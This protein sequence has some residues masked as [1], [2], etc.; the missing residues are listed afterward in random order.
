MCSGWQDMYVEDTMPVCWYTQITWCCLMSVNAQCPVWW[1]YYNTP[2]SSIIVI[3]KQWQ[4]YTNECL[5][6]QIFL[7]KSYLKPVGI[8]WKGPMS[9]CDEK[10]FHV[11]FF[12]VEWW[13][14]I[15]SDFVC[16]YIVCLWPGEDCMSQLYSLSVQ[17]TNIRFSEMFTFIGRTVTSTSHRWGGASGL[18]LIYCLHCK[19]LHCYMKQKFVSFPSIYD[20]FYSVGSVFSQYK[21][22]IFVKQLGPLF[23]YFYL[24]LW[25]VI[26]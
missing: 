20:F 2:F 5:I 1:L 26:V 4:W 7:L 15:W 22:A 21:I 17:H 24:C 18:L 12:L 23:Q 13:F 10:F 8:M 16:M 14:V 3:A 9:L 6:M 19:K 11:F 25:S